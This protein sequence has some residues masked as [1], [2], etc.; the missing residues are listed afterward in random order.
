MKNPIYLLL[1]FVLASF[2]T[3][4]ETI[5]LS[6]KIT[7]TE[8][9]KIK[10][11]GESFEKEITLNPDGTFSETFPI[12]Y[13]GSYTIGTSKNRT[14]L[15]LS[16]GTKLVLTADDKDFNTTLKF[17][18]KGSVENQYVVEKSKVTATVTNEALY[19]LEEIEFLKKI[20]EIKSTIITLYDK[21]KFSDINFK[22]KEAKNIT[23]L[24]QLYLL[25]YPSYHAHYAKI[26]GFNASE[27][28]PKF[29]ETINLDD[30]GDYLFS[31]TY[32]QIVNA[33]FNKKIDAQVANE[34]E[35]ISKYALPIIKTFK[36][37]NI[38]NALVQGLSYEISAGNVDAEKLY[39]DLILLSTD[40]KFKENLALK[41]NKIKTLAIGKPS[42][43]F[44]YENHKGGKTSLESLKG[45]YV[46]VD[47]WATWCGPCRK[48]IPSLKKV[49]EQYH[50][51]NI[52]FVSISIDA[53]KDHE[54]WNKFVTEKQL[55]GI[56]L[57]ADKDWNS[58]FVKEYAIDGIPRF[59][60][61]G[62]NGDIINADAPR[63][64]DT[65]LIDLFNNLKI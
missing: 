37:Q 54:K 24:E 56:Q 31:N 52:E 38:K 40:A 10:I 43:K 30:D 19:K 57:F 55:G 63:P 59:I 46:Y 12:D 9:G 15:Y 62:P 44:D 5:I 21:T 53:L 41:F 11:K 16:N 1:L 14:S 28:F 61:I 34:E 7:N 27:S 4:K 26:E 22:E 3:P 6:G 18:G 49:E 48:E 8:D 25:N 58:Q 35:M 20:N 36:S 2:T 17:T 50:G 39:N 47:V 45:K 13:I 23:Y 29:D 33:K 32:K 65:K 51:K 42:P 64:S 60:L